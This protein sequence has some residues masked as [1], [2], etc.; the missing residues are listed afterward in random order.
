MLIAWFHSFAFSRFQDPPSLSNRLVRS[1][2]SESF[3]AGH[4]AAV[5]VA[6]VP[7]RCC[8]GVDGATFSI[9]PSIL[10]LGEFDSDSQVLAVDGNPNAA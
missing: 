1:S 7:G 6:A 8:S 10:V 9:H 3:D 4:A 2:I 5:D